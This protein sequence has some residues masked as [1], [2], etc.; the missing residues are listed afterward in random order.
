MLEHM[1]RELANIHAESPSS[2]N[3][4]LTHLRSLDSEWL[5]EASEILSRATRNDWKEWAR[6]HRSAP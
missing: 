5:L 2:L 1:G 6:R 4:V 3:A